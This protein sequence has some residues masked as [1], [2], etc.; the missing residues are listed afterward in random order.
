VVE[1]GG[2]PFREAVDINFLTREELRRYIDEVVDSEYPPARATA[3]Q[4]MLVAFDL[5]AAGVDLRHTRRQLL[6]DN[7]AGFY[8]E[9]P[10]R[11][12]LYAVS[13]ER[14]LTP[15]NELVLAHELRH[16]QQ[17]QYM[18]VY[19]L[20]PR[21]V[22]DFDDRRLAILSLLEGD[23]TLLMERFLDRDLKG[24]GRASR[25]ADDW[26]ALTASMPRA[27]AVVRDLMVLPYVIGARF[28][29]EVWSRQ[30]GA[31]MREV[32]SR[33]PASTE[34]ILHPEKY[35]AQEAPEPA[36]FDYRPA[37]AAAVITAGVLGEAFVRTLLG[38]AADATVAAAGWGG[39]RYQVW[40]V[41]GRTLLLWRST[42]DTDGDAKE[43]AAALLA[44]YARSHT[45]TR[46]R[47]GWTV[48][49]KGAWRLGLQR[50][51]RDVWLVSGDAA[52]VVERAMKSLPT[53]GG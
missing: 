46:A 34:Q 48:Y 1:I 19:D 44:R 17:D 39:D 9:R 7:I 5:L 21:D 4:R 33:P 52:R 30:G 35:W 20:L 10:H 13:E 6:Q 27:P 16:A 2:V 25:A 24:A 22:S 53:T 38:A 51:G 26:A 45:R 14:R 29:D 18:K 28:A 32:W 43:L 15:Q 8:D 41:S 37:G 49:R 31:G 42:W 23:A 40:D 3:D 50:R 47:E 12:R 11:R 36:A